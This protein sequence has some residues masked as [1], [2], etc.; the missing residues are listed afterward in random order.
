VQAGVG[1]DL[2]AKVLDARPTS[3]DGYPGRQYALELPESKMP[4]G[5]TYRARAY[6]VNQRLYQVVAV[7]PRANASPTDAEKFF[8]SF[9]LSAGR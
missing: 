9:R 3:L 6:L 2:R 7:T 5:G 4:G 1:A 8:R